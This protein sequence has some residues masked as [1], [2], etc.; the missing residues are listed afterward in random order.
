MAYEGRIFV[1]SSTGIF[2]EEMKDALELDETMRSLFVN[3]GGHSTIVGPGGK[4]IAGPLPG[5]RIIYADLNLE[6][7]IAGKFIHDV[8]GHYNRFDIF[9]LR[10]D[11]RPRQPLV[12]VD[13]PG[14]TIEESLRPATS[15]VESPDHLQQ[16]PFDGSPW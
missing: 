7:I 2:S 13:S 6:A 10:V 12:S 8:T 3:D 15:G 5:E 4:V 11:R 1:L 14:A 16:V 9:T